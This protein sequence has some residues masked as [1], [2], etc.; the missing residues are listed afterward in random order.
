MG[1]Q[2]KN[3]DNIQIVYWQIELV[4]SSLEVVAQDSDAKARAYKTAIFKFDCLITLAAC[5]HVYYCLN[6]SHPGKVNAD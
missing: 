6:K 4:M 5:E 2:S 3:T 1:K